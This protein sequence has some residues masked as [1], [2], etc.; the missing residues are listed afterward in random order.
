MGAWVLVPLSYASDSGAARI[1][2]QGAKARERS[3]QAG[4]GVGGGFPPP[5]SREIFRKFG[6]ENCIFVHIKCHYLGVDY[7]KYSIHQPLPLLLRVWEGEA[8]PR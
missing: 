3:D 6:Y 1:C 7:M 8:L 4:E 5:R 2:Q